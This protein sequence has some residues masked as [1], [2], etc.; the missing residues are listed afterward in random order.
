MLPVAVSPPPGHV[1]G[2][3]FYIVRIVEVISLIVNFNTVRPGATEV[4]CTLAL[5]TSLNL[6]VRRRNAAVLQSRAEAL[7]DSLKR[8]GV[9]NPHREA[10]L[11]TLARDHAA[12]RPLE[13]GEVAWNGLEDCVHRRVTEA[14]IAV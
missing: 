13:V 9:A 12:E 10:L 1:F 14:D 6:M 3:Y 5:Q 2:P 4:T 11:P 8:V 7:E